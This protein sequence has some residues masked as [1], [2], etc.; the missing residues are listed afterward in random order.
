MKF[1]IITVTYN[2]AEFLEKTILSVLTQS[3]GNI[4]YIIVDGASKDGT[5]DI[6]RQ[7]ESGIAH[8]ISEA[9]TGLYDAMNKGLALSTG[10]YVWFINAGD[11]LYS[12]DIVS[13]MV[14]R[15]ATYRPKKQ[16]VLGSVLPD[17]LYGETELMDADGKTLGM[18]RLKAPDK[19]TWKSFRWGML[20]CHQSF[21]L[22]RSLAPMYDLKYRYCADIEWCISG[23]KAS[24]HIFNTRLTLSRFLEGGMSDK[25][26][27]ASLE[28]RYRIMCTHYGTLSTLV[29]HGWFAFRFGF[30]KLIGKKQ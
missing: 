27:K 8:W 29:M 18:R 28:E 21:V 20:V 13:Q 12:V 1:S 22:K 3:Y 7:Y 26:R 23:M 17:I 4:E 24:K 15:I 6:I 2:A 30:S 14:E 9:D 11:C 10:D 25:Q 5:L 16:A 19:L